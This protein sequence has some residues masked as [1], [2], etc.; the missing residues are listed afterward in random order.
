MVAAG[1]AYREGFS[2]NFALIERIFPDL[3]DFGIAN[4]STG[5]LATLETGDFSRHIEENQPAS[6]RVRHLSRKEFPITTTS[7]SAMVNAAMVGFKKP[8][9][10]KGIASTL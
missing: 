4:E 3:L 2:C 10:A 1:G 9:A 5:F 7:E 6:L 8:Q